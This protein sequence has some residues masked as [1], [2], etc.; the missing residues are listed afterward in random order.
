MRVP[1][2]PYD[3]AHTVRRIRRPRAAFA[4]ARR[5][6]IR[7]RF[8]SWCLPALVLASCAGPDRA[9]RSAESIEKTVYGMLPAIERLSGLAARLPVRVA[10]TSPDSL[11]AYITD[12]LDRY[13]PAGQ[14]EGMRRA[15]VMLGLLPDTLDLR[16]LL[17]ELYGEQV[18]GYYDPETT[19]L[20]AVDS[21]A[22]GPIEP[23]LAHELVHA[24]QDQA[25]NLDSLIT[26]NERNDHQSAAQA[27]IEG[28]ATL[29]MYAWMAERTAGDTV[30]PA[31]LPD[32]AAT[33][34]E[35]FSAQERQFPVFARAPRVIRETLLFPYAQGASFVRALWRA[36]PSS[37][38]PPFGDLL[39]QST[40]QVLD[41]RSLPDHRDEPTGIGHDAVDGWTPVYENTLGQFETRIFIE[42]VAG[43]AGAGARGWDGDRYTL[44]APVAG[45]V[46]VWTSVWDDAA[47]AD[48]FARSAARVPARLGRQGSA[49]RI[50]IEGR[51]GVRIV[52]GA[53]P[54][55]APDPTVR[56]VNATGN[57]IA[58]ATTG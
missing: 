55:A 34:S 13:L 15:Y 47:A 27:A 4:C 51:P 58:C 20:Y 21:D 52:I 28:H 6:V 45:D 35:L 53:P 14:L 8:V 18:A 1:G 25:V 49:R 23:V 43:E 3:F 57:R 7:T 36:D 17:L 39:P 2:L 9:D 12:R 32:P 56:C 44:Y 40:E 29:V 31:S 48:S 24:L 10:R 19:T 46:L 41:L 38:R 50:D 16:K 37:R 22:A 54:S 30:N 33:A 5:L 11:E 26:Q 42:D